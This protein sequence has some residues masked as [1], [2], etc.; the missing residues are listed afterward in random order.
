MQRLPSACEFFNNIL[1]STKELSQEEALT[2]ALTLHAGMATL[3]P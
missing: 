1:G 2:E 3:P